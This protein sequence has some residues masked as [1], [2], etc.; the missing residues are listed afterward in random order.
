MNSTTIL[1]ESTV[2]STYPFGPSVTVGVG[3]YV[4]TK[5]INVSYNFHPLRRSFRL[6]EENPTTP[7]LYIRKFSPGRKVTLPLVDLDSVLR[8]MCWVCEHMGG[9]P[10]D[11]G[12]E[13]RK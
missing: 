11:S 9:E 13:E 2:V 4:F 5:E 3:L 12:K 8:Y 10:V 6:I 1:P 7:P